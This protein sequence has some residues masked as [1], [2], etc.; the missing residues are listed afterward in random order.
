MRRR[1]SR[2]RAFARTSS[3]GRAPL[4]KRFGQLLLIVPGQPARR[5]RLHL[6]LVPLFAANGSESVDPLAEVHP[7]VRWRPGCRDCSR[8]CD[9]EVIPKLGGH[10]T[11]QVPDVRGGYGHVPD[12][13]GHGLSG[14]DHLGVQWTDA[15]DLVGSDR[16]PANF[17]VGSSSSW[18]PAWRTAGRQPARAVFEEQEDEDDQMMCAKSAQVTT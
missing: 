12:I 6:L 17:V 13:Q 16:F 18:N 7:P 4:Q 15:K 14:E 9:L 8:Q 11:R 1:C 2:P 3:K 5:R 10:K